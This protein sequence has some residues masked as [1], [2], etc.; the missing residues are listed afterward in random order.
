[1]TIERKE[2]VKRGR[3]STGTN[4]EAQVIV[5]LD[6]ELLNNLDTMVDQ[7]RKETGYNVTRSDIIRKAILQAVK[8]YSI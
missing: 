7:V 3:P 8:D 5:R 6:Q 2:P 4:K 1:M